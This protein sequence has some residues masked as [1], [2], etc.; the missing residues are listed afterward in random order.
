MGGPLNI[1]DYKGHLQEFREHLTRR[2]RVPSTTKLDEL[3]KNFEALE[4]QDGVELGKLAREVSEADELL[5]IFKQL[6]LH[7]DRFMVTPDTWAAILQDKSDLLDTKCSAGRDLQYELWLVA[8]LNSRGIQA[9]WTGGGDNT[10]C[11]FLLSGFDFLVEAKRPKT[12]QSIPNVISKAVK[13]SLRKRL[14]RKPK[15]LGLV[16]ISL[17]VPI[18]VR[19]SPAFQA[20]AL[21]RAPDKVGWCRKTIDGALIRFSPFIST[22]FG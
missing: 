8:Y 4:N 16:A 6:Q 14:Y 5:L 19:K 13:R 9:Q 17:N 15:A 2:Q 21:A 22:W 10:D 11:A 7:P 18:G 20:E 12:A 3:I 1:D